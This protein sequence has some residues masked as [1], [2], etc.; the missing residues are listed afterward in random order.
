[1]TELDAR[2]FL[3]RNGTKV[4]VT[5]ATRDDRVEFVP[6]KRHRLRVWQG[7]AIATSLALA[8]CS[9]PK[10]MMPGV[11]PLPAPDPSA[12]P[13]PPATPSSAPSASAVAARPSAEP[14]PSTTAT[15]DSAAPPAEDADD[16]ESDGPSSR[17]R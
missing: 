16:L 11:A 17:V 9:E 4:C 10:M 3:C 7:A 1:M 8:A 12:Q 13:D 14:A 15:S 2:R 6:E 5:Y